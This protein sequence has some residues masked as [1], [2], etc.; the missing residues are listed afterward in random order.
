M[1]DGRAVSTTLSYVLTLAISALLVTGLVTAGG[2]YVQ[3]EREQVIR[4]ELTVIGQQIAADVERADR[5]VRAANTDD[6]VAVQLNQSFAASVTGSSYRI[7][8]D[9]SGPSV[10]VESIDPDISVT[11]EVNT[12]TDLADTTADG[13]NIQIRFADTDGDSDPDALEVQNG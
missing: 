5:L 13:G 1:S 7:S 8:L 4:D 12:E 9:S 2:N 11:V 10:V 3:S 6:S